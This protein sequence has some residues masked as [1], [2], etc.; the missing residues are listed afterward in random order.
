MNATLTTI[1]PADNEWLGRAVPEAVI[2]PSLS[3]IDTHMH[4]WAYDGHRY[5]L[6]EYARDVAA[7]GHNVEAS[8]YVECFAMYRAHGPEQDAPVGDA[9]LVLG[10][11]GRGQAGPRQARDDVRSAP[12]RAA[13]AGAGEP[14]RAGTRRSHQLRNRAMMIER[15]QR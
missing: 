5:F 1:A 7:C 11:R 12:D 4:L 15:R 14:A 2:E 9:G 6:E 8:V 10:G 13:G 3:I